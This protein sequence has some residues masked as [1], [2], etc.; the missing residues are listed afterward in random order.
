MTRDPAVWL[1]DFSIRRPPYE[2]PQAEILAWL[3]EIHADAEATRAGLSQE[4]RDAFRDRLDRVIDRCACGPA[5]IARRGHA[6]PDLH[7]DR[8]DAILYDVRRDPSGGDTEARTR[9]F[10]EIVGAYLE[11][12]YARDAAPP[13][14][15][16]HVTCTG[17]ASPSA[18]QQLVARKGWGAH[19]RV[20]HAYHMG[21]YAALPAVRLAAASLAAPAALA[22][23]GAAPRVDVVHTELCSLHLD[24]AAHSIEQLV[25]QSL[26]ADGLIRYR[27]VPAA[28]RPGLRLLA[29]AEVIVPG[30]A[31]A[32][33]WIVAGH[34]MQMTLARDVPE[35][36]RGVL[37]EVVTDLYA[38][39][40]LDAAA[41]LPRSAAAIHP[42]GPKILD[43]VRDALG[44]REAQLATSRAVLRDFGNMSSATLPHVWARLLD[45]PGVRA[46]TPVLSLAFG[47]GLTVCA[48]LLR[49]E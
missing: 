45:D 3:A 27:V 26:F 28:E 30:T 16:L 11:E 32:M 39:A 21:C 14:D 17:Y 48:A 25:V 34:G 2:T 19:T 38:R 7:R 37:A 8:S 29:L 13:L 24:P 44:L 5:Q 12:E 20:T 23:G 33:R 31:D 49:K 4:A 6:V 36:L 1:T 43:R 47:P 41:H 9:Y 15:L 18:A 40:G 42:G 46:G 35:K 22:P 10:A